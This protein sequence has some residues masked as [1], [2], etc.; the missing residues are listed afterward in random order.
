M[1]VEEKLTWWFRNCKTRMTTK[2]FADRYMVTQD[3]M[4]TTLKKLQSEGKVAPVKKGRQIYWMSL[5]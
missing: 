1:V 2:D 4:R 3:H 5:Q